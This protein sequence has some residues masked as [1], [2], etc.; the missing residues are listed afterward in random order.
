MGRAVSA[1]P[2]RHGN[3]DL[4]SRF[5]PCLAVIRRP[6]QIR[7][8][9]ALVVGAF[10]AVA[11]LLWLSVFGYVL[12]LHSV[13][14]R[15]RAP[16]VQSPP[17]P[18]IGV[19]V[20][21]LNE[22]RLIVGKLRDLRRSAYPPE[23]MTIVVVDGGSTDGTVELVQREIAAGMAAQ[24]IH[25]AELRG[26]AAQLNRALATLSQEIV[27]VTDVDA[28]LDPQCIAELVRVVAGDA[29]TALVG[30][31]VWPAS[32]LLEERLHWRWLNYLWWLEGEV[33]S[34]GTVAAP[35]YAIRRALLPALA[36]DVRADDI[37]LAMAASAR[38]LRVRT[39]RTAHATEVRV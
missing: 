13:A 12:V 9:M 4:G 29:R 6:C 10:A 23:R 28:R 32:A 7:Q 19:V 18:E 5:C 1:R 30:A 11:S 24:L 3:A 14:R 15:R 25:D 21:T 16:I 34:F 20:P 38:G 2:P 35:C 8:R 33:L 22:A 31:T 37:H 36:A 26:K 39:C 27:I 17:L